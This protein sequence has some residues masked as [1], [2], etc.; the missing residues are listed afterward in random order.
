MLLR[1]TRFRRRAG[2]RAA[3]EAVRNLRGS[4][5]L[6][7]HHV[8]E[9]FDRDIWAAID[10]FSGVPLSYADA[11]LVVLGRRLRIRQAFSFDVDLRSA[12]LDLV[13]QA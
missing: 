11:S 8:D 12:G 10:E 3:A 13:P 4:Q 5:V 9:A 6:S 7:V 2:Y 1:P